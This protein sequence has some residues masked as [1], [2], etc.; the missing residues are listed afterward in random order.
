M[1]SYGVKPEYT[2]WRDEELSRRHRDWGWN[3]PATD[4]DFV[5][6]E[7][8]HRKPVAIVDYKFYLKRR[9]DL[10]EAN[11]DA[12]ADLADNYAPGALPFIIPIYSKDPW[13]FVVISRN[14]RAKQ[15]YGAEPQ[16]Y[17]EQEYVR[18][19]YS[20]R[21]RMLEFIDKQAIEKLTQFKLDPIRV[22][23]NVNGADRPVVEF[24]P[25]YTGQA[26]PCNHP[27]FIPHDGGGMICATVGCGQ[28]AR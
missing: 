9:V 21:K 28:I 16:Y 10:R 26:S 24:K 19:L 22:V 17:S 7:Y 15:I 25:G 3:C 13:W 8:N 18:S 23:L 5:L 1:P 20:L 14:E 11:F 27:L 12:I 2:G 6:L 4:L